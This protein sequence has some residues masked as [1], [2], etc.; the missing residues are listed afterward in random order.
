MQTVLITGANRGIGLEL[1]RLY[2]ARGDRVIACCRDPECAAALHE[3][4]G[5]EI[6][7]L[8]VTS[9]DDIADLKAALGT[10][11][12]DILINNAG[13]IGPERQ[14]AL[15]MDFD[16]W[17]KTFEVNTLGPLRLAA[18][19][20]DNLRRAEAPKLVTLSSRM[21]SLTGGGGSDRIAYRSSKAAINRAMQGLA[22]DL[23]GE[24][25]TVVVVHPG[26][27]STDMG[28]P[29]APLAPR[30]SATRL[31]AI[32]AALDHGD[33]GRFIDIDGKDA[34]W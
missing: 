23:R 14:S 11:P 29:A 32:I 25:I 19:L 26:W 34:D 27:V 33:S 31:A 24:R 22:E 28:G 9:V 21:G 7:R 10:R 4:D 20:L 12:I 15:N 16:G 18:A 13:I 8:D 3:L 2:A 17:L 6:H 1:A 30:E 5:I